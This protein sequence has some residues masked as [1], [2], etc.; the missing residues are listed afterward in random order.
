MSGW[1]CGREV[2]VELIERLCVLHAVKYILLN[3]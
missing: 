1:G 2:E 3:F